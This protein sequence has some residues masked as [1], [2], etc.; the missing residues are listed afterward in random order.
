MAFETFS[1][2]ESLNAASNAARTGLAMKQ[3]GDQKE[4]QQG[5]REARRDAATGDP[6]SI[7][8]LLAVD[9]EGGGK[10]IDSL[11]KMDKLGREKVKAQ[12]AETA[13]SMMWVMQGQ[14]DQERS[15]RWDQ[16][17]EYMKTTNPEAPD[18]KGKYSEGLAQQFIMKAMSVGEIADEFAFG[19]VK[20]GM[21]DNK[22]V[23]FA[24]N[25]Q[26]QAQEI[27]G[28][29]PTEKDV[30][31]TS[32]GKGFEMKASD[33]NSIRA[34][35]AGLFGGIW[36]PATGRVSGV[37]KDMTAKVAA[38]SEEASRIYKESGG[39]KTHDQAAAEAARKLGIDIKDLSKTGKSIQ[40]Y[41]KAQK[42][43]KAE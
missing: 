17:S 4:Q 39:S 29:T 31:G 42:S 9:P 6:D 40:D 36:D 10:I 41:L 13:K 33:S 35:A 21:K 20:V 14:N 5:I 32:G 24:T 2:A 16:V 19:Q 26:G 27:K 11:S 3:Y 25:K 15:Q 23:Y 28:V 22:P 1:L 43:P 12:T 34:A 8:R 30:K 7:K 18:L 37:S 38:V